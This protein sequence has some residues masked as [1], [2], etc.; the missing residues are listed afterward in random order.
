M[1]NPPTGTTTLTRRMSNVLA[2]LEATYGPRIWHS[3]G[4]PLD[5]LIGTVLSQHTSDINT[6]RAFAS[7]KEQFPEWTL[8][9]EAPVDGVAGAIRSGGLAEQKAPRIQGILKAIDAERHVLDIEHLRRMPLEAA[10]AWLLSLRGVG[11]KTAACVLLFSLGRPA[12]PVDTHVHRVAKRLGLI[13]STIGADAAH[14]ILEA[15]LGGDRDRVY[16]FHLTMIAHGRA[17]C[18]ARRSYCERCPL[19]ECCDYFNATQHDG[20]CLTPAPASPGRG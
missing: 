19:T 5:E 14:G 15:G 10:R 6:A 1:T 4:D 9:L 16:A 11:P 2:L 20:R 17:V 7:L 3:H 12:L 18:T 13:G 8:V